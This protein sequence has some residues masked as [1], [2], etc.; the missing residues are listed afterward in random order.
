MPRIQLIE[1]LTTEPVPLGSNILVEFDAASMWY[2]ASLTIAA[3]WLRTGGKV[4]Y[5]AGAQFPDH[6]R[7][8]LRR[9]GLDVG[10]LEAAEKLLIYDYYT[11]ALGQASKEKLAPP[12]LKVQDL[13]I[14]YS[15]VHRPTLTPDTLR[16]H[17]NRSN[18][19][20]FNE[21]R[22][23]IEY[24]LTRT[25]ALGSQTKSTYISGIIGGV[26]SESVYKQFE[27]AADGIVDF[28]LEEATGGVT[29]EVMRIRTMKNGAFTRGWHAL[30]V[31]ENFEVTLE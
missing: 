29:R 7:E 28:R 17:E 9:L 26:H 23:W 31:N 11:P 15:R 19:A 25:F 27:A 16:I 4:V 18:L 24:T 30:K 6:V 8:R 5:Y 13:S 10:N 22:S 1:D 20:R 12:S 14:W 3:E 2:A 21:E